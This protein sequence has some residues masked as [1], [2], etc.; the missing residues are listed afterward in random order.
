MPSDSNPVI[1]SVDV[2]IKN[3]GLC[4]F[5]PGDCTI[6][7]WGVVEVCPA[8]GDMAVAV[9]RT[10]QSN[11]WWQNAGRVVIELQPGRNRRMMSIQHFLH[12]FCVMNDKPV[13]IFSA[14]RKLA[15]TGLENK[16]RSA[17]QYRARKKASILLCK[18]WLEAQPQ[19]ARWVPGFTQKGV[20]K[21][22]LAD[23]L[24]QALAFCHIGNA[25]DPD[26]LADQG[27]AVHA[28]KPTQRQE[29]R[30]DY[31]R[32]NLK[33]ILCK[34]WAGIPDLAVQIRADVKVHRCVTR[35]Y[36]TIECCIAQLCPAS[37]IM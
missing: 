18:Q 11:G 28:R 3:L 14:R 10:M 31:S 22:D 21:D 24:N 9:R 15:G 19:N 34:K 25:A 4:L 23:S 37:E 27:T 36:G 29:S 7:Q 1:L 6:L 2:G 17:Q 8:R 32:S 16:G 30:G 35:H 33:H 26:T 5:S 12:M 13:T 20:K